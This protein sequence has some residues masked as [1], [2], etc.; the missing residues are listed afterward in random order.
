MTEMADYVVRDARF[1]GSARTRRYD[2]PLRFQR[3]DVFQSGFVVTQSHHLGT[4]FRQ[5]LV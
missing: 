1:P 5:I 3:L 2:N 4:Q